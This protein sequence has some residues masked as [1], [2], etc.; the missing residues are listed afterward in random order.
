MIQKNL[1]QTNLLILLNIN[2]YCEI[3]NY[4]RLEKQILLKN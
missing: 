2:N 4:R 1:K 3:K